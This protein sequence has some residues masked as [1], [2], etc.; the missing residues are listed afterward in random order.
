MKPRICYLVFAVGLACLA[1]SGFLFLQA[2]KTTCY[3]HYTLRV[4]YKA[5]PATDDALK[6]WLGQQPEGYKASVTRS[7]NILAFD[8]TMTNAAPDVFGALMRHC[9]S[10]GY[11]DRVGY[12]G[13]FGPYR[14]THGTF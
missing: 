2:H 10:N 11:S 13:G 1:L 6:T 14:M 5:L 9:E 7:G 12:I 4:E 3:S 8:V